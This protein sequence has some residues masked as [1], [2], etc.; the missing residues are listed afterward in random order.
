DL[1]DAY[2]FV[3]NNG[4]VSINA[5]NYSNVN[6]TDQITWTVIPNLGRT[7]SA[8]TVEPANADRQIPNNYSPYVEYDFTLFSSGKLTIDTYVSPTLNYKKNEGLKYAI[9]I[10]EEEPQIINIH[11]G[12]TQPDWE[13]PAWWNNSVTDHIKKK[14]STHTVSAAGKH[15]LKVWMVD[16]GVV[17]Q[18]FVIDAGGLRP[19]YL[20]PRES[21]NTLIKI[22]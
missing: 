11:E 2:G 22:K 8:I 5:A 15:T 3:E 12:E 7:N 9:S 18:K 13:Y 20:G 19:S 21:L 4:V 17:F 6:N 1:R 10:D 14:Q 16:P